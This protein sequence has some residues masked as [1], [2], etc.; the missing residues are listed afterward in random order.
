MGSNQDFSTRKAREML[1]WEP[2]VDYETGL[3]ATMEWLQAQ[4]LSHA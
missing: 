1:G 3:R 2:R 4:R